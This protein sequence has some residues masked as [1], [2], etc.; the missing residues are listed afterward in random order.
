MGQHLKQGIDLFESGAYFRAH[1]EFEALWLAS[2]GPARRLYQGLVQA[3]AGLLKSE[4]GE[5]VGA[6]RLLRR[7]LAN[8]EQAVAE[9][10]RSP[11]GIDLPRFIIGLRSAAG[12][13][14]RG[15]PVV[16]PRIRR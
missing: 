4:R 16:A 15:E 6:G 5:P 3:A 7:A 11:A 13:V 8:I 9:G 12:A 2:Q 10:A 1:E 14:E